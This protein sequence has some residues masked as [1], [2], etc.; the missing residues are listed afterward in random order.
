MFTWIWHIKQIQDVGYELLNESLGPRV[1]TQNATPVIKLCKVKRIGEYYTRNAGEKDVL[2]RWKG[3]II[4]FWWMAI[5]LF[6]EGSMMLFLTSTIR[7][8][9]RPLSYQHNFSYFLVCEDFLVVH[10]LARMVVGIYISRCRTSVLNSNL[11]QRSSINAI[12]GTLSSRCLQSV[13]AQQKHPIV[14]ESSWRYTTEFHKKTACWDVYWE[15]WDQ[16][17]INESFLLDQI[18]PRTVIGFGVTQSRR[19]C[20]CCRSSTS[21][22]LQ[23]RDS[24]RKL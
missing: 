23:V 1:H 7:W 14:H 10:R 12:C 13:R 5:Q 2:T 21:L 3:H 20:F 15:M 17:C 22:R 4:Y 24:A 8:A 18:E 16:S 6:C 9:I 19:L 11:Y